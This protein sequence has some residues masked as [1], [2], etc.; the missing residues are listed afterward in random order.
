MSKRRRVD[1]SDHA[2]LRYLER[3]G[4]FD[5]EGLR[6]SIAD[7]LSDLIICAPQTVVV[8]GFRF[9]VKD[10]IAGPVVVTV[11]EKDRGVSIRDTSEG[12]R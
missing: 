1:V 6:R 4:G 7:R 5:I 2:V 9:L 8:G 10:G 12:E 3:V 11:I